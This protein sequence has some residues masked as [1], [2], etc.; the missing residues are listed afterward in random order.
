[1]RFNRYCKQKAFNAIVLN[2]LICSQMV[3][4]MTETN[5]TL[6]ND[7]LNVW[8]ESIKKSIAEQEIELI[9]LKTTLKTIERF[10]SGSTK[11]GEFNEKTA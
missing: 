1:M 9:K 4:K 8:I 7:E 2:K 10:K 11:V 6:R 3:E 5:E